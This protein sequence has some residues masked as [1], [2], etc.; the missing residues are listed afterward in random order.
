M[1]QDGKH[2][3]VAGTRAKSLM[4]SLSNAVVT[5]DGL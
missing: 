1:A 5:C 4:D 3:P 2:A